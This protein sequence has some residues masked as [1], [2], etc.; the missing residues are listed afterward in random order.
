MAFSPEAHERNQ[1]TEGDMTFYRGLRDAT[2]EYNLHTKGPMDKF[3]LVY[4]AT[5][6]GTN[7]IISKSSN[8]TFE[9]GDHK[10]K[11]VESPLPPATQHGTGTF[12]NRIALSEI[13]K[14]NTNYNE[15]SKGKRVYTSSNI[16]P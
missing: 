6:T 9:Y 5:V 7:H 4:Q 1:R 2:E 3:D 8:V 12:M 13:V 16:K 11:E 14:G 15:S 10:N